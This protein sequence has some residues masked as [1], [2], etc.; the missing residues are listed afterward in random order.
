[1]PLPKFLLLLFTIAVCIVA[2]KKEE[3][4]DGGTI[5]SPKV[6]VTT[7]DYLKNNPDKRFDT[8]ITLIDA[9]G[10]KDVVNEQGITFFSP[11]NA[12]I[13]YYIAKRALDEYSLDPTHTWTLDSVLKYELPVI[14][15]FVNRSIVKQVLTYDKLTEAGT[16]YQT[17]DTAS[18]CIVSYERTQ[19]GSLGYNSI[20]SNPLYVEYFYQ[21]LQPITPPFVASEL[22]GD[23]VNRFRVQTSGIQTTTGLLNIL[24]DTE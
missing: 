6:N 15:F 11:T 24:K 19:E 18:Q 8:L 13:R 14:R 9:A 16:L 20:V 23:E 4:A 22:G 12:S 2:C 21:V 3:Y 1:M 17:A 7:Y 10:L 5:V